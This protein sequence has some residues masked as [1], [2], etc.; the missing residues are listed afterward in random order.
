MNAIASGLMMMVL[1]ALGTFTAGAQIG[2]WRISLV[3]VV[4]GAAVPFIA[5]LE[6]ATLLVTLVG[7]ALLAIFGF[8]YSHRHK[9]T[10]TAA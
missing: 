8:Y 3:G 10:S 4:L 1:L 7:V 2:A 6:R 9:S 5:F